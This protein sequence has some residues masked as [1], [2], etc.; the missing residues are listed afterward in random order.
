MPTGNAVERKVIEQVIYPEFTKT[1]FYN[2]VNLLLLN[3]PVKLEDHTKIELE[4]N[5]DDLVPADGQKV[6]VLGLGRLHHK[7]DTPNK[8]R[9]VEVEKT[10][11]EDC[12]R[13]HPSLK[14]E[15]SIQLC[16]GTQLI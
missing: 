15:D 6:T 12:Q 2:D 4:L 10:A 16:A 7:G 14:I 9:F 1:K 8:V 5:S 11:D 13:A 3:E